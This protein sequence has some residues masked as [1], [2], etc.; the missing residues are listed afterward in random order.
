MKGVVLLTGD[1]I[2]K[3]KELPDECVQTVV[4]SP[5]YF[6]LRS[7]GVDGQIGQE[8]TPQEFVDTLVKVFR[9]VRRVLRKDGTVWLNLGDSFAGSG[10]GLH[11]DGQSHGTEGTK[12]RTN[13][14]S[15]GAFSSKVHAVPKNAGEPR[16]VGTVFDMRDK[17]VEA[18]AI[19][20]SWV[21]PPPGL[22]QKDL[23]GIPWRVAFALQADGWWLRSDI[24]WAKPNTMPE[25]VKDRPTTS[26]EYIFL[27]TK[28]RK[29]FY[30]HVAILEPSTGQV[31]SA[32]NF[33]RDSKEALVPGQTH[34]QHRQDRTPTEDKGQRN[35]RDVWFVPSSPFKGA[36]FATFPPKLIE[37]CILAGTSE[38]GC[39][40]Y[41]GAPWKRMT[42]TTAMVIRPSDRREAAQEA[43]SGSGRTATSGTMLEPPTTT[44]VGWEPT[45]THEAP[46]V[47][48][49]VLDPF[50]G[51][52]TTG[53]VARKHGRYFVG[54]DLNPEYV[55][56]AKERIR[57]GK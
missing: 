50:I 25:S 10:R 57:N 37:P 45:C 1:V 22:K 34:T 19:G 4:T 9:E 15:I 56:M 3:L 44:T 21:K 28:N 55:K 35:K 29:Y 14:G 33:Q 38:H 2:D 17:R 32:A 12:Q 20:R 46:V 16:T 24:I 40:S 47:P 39:C 36:H 51:S 13:V 27:L 31:G 54:I 6:G 23:I 52:G 7:Y 30:D 48:C 11:G 5:P 43:G 49:L 41:C 53:M 8:P 18:G 26:H 42:E